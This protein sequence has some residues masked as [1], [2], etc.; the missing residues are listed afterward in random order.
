LFRTFKNFYANLQKLRKKVILTLKI[1]SNH[2]KARN[3]IVGTFKSQTADWLILFYFIFVGM[4]YRMILNI[5]QWLTLV[6]IAEQWNGELSEFHECNYINSLPTVAETCP[7]LLSWC[8]TPRQP[9]KVKGH[10][11]LS[12]LSPKWCWF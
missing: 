6:G 8:R 11:A 1:Y 2:F 3:Q 4:D 9:P 7:D 10:I 5:A 12:Y